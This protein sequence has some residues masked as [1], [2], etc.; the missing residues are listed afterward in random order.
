MVLM[1]MIM[2]M[3]DDNVTVL[4][5]RRETFDAMVYTF[6]VSFLCIGILGYATRIDI[7]G[8]AEGNYTLLA[9]KAYP[10]SVYNYSMRPV[11]N[12]KMDASASIPVSG[13]AFRVS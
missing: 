9:L 4:N 5:G 13:P 1:T 3:I 6:F 10:S 7:N 8:D 12:F 2:K 11:A